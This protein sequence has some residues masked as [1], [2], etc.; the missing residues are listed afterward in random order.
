MSVRLPEDRRTIAGRR[1]R[2]YR[3]RLQARAGVMK[4]RDPT[5][6]SRTDD[7]I[8]L[9][10]SR[11]IDP[12]DTRTEL[13]EGIGQQGLALIV[14]EIRLDVSVAAQLGGD[15]LKQRSPSPVLTP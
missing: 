14:V 8:F 3:R 11:E 1:S 10:V 4:K 6:T 13:A 12:R 9:P 7:Q 15:V 2:V 5:R